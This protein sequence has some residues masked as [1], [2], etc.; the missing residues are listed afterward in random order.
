MS[1]FEVIDTV[2]KAIDAVG[3][4]VIAFGVLISASIAASRL[5]RRIPEVYRP[6]RQQLGRSILL[7]LAAIEFAKKVDHINHLNLS[8]NLLSDLLGEFLEGK[9]GA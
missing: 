7:G 2:G 1:F 4:A 6:F 9:V 8:P 5:R 3:V